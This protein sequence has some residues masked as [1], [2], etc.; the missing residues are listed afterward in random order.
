MENKHLSWT[1]KYDNTTL[2][3]PLGHISNKLN[4]I[5]TLFV[6]EE[7]IRYYYILREVHISTPNSRPS[8]I[9]NPELQYR[10]K[11]NP[12]LSNPFKLPSPLVF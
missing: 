2:L 11:H 5:A 9:Y 10:L 3:L 8:L 6:Q 12:Q 4:D 7:N 1:R